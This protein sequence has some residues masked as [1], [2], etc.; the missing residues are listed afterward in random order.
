MG[1]ATTYLDAAGS[2]VGKKESIADTARVLSSM[3]DGIEYRGFGQKIVER[4][5]LNP[6]FP[7]LI[8]LSHGNPYIRVDYIHILCRRIHILR[9]GD[10]CTRLFS[11]ERRTAIFPDRS[12]ASTL[13]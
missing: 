9:Q 10:A 7:H 12:C 8:R 4:K 2:Q 5:R 1:I 11:S 13:A 6:A 3:Y